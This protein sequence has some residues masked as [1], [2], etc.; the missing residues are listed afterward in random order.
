MTGRPGV[1]ALLARAAQVVLAV[2][3]VLAMHTFSIGH[4]PALP[5]SA[6]HA[7]TGSGASSMTS[8]DDA[9][10]QEAPD[11]CAADACLHPAG[12]SRHGGHGAMAVCVPLLLGAVLLLLALLAIARARRASQLTVRGTG[13]RCRRVDR[14]PP[15][16]Q[17][18]LSLSE[19]SLL[20]V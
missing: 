13:A 6:H 9:V 8:M 11:G 12:P 18:S 1:H 3:G 16:R 20:R 15:Q 7:L 2:A 19:L 4:M 14:G 17:M 5:A 10:T